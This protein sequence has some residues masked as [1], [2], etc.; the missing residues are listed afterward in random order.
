MRYCRKCG[1]RLLR[2]D[3]EAT[4]NKC[5]NPKPRKR[6]TSKDLGAPGWLADEL[7]AWLDDRAS[8]SDQEDTNEEWGLS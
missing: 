5:L 1:A 2:R 8:Q 6:R 7:Q 4:C 3:K